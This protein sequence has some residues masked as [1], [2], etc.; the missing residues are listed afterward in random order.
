MS[1]EASPDLSDAVWR[2]SRRSSAESSNCVEVAHIADALV[3]RD[4]K[5]P[6]ETLLIFTRSQWLA[7]LDGVKSARFDLT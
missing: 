1:N 2:K 7:F 4:S 3:V 6:S 5:N